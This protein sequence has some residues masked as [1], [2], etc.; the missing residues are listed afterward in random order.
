MYVSFYTEL[1]K[2]CPTWLY[3]F[4]FPPAFHI[5]IVLQK[6]KVL[7]LVQVGLSAF[8]LKV[9]EIYLFILFAKES[10]SNIN[11]EDFLLW[12]LL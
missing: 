3:H 4:I 7:I 5:L 9:C 8:F 10:L 12:F 11:G 2:N 1:T 6:L